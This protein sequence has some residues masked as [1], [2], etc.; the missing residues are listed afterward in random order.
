MKLKPLLASLYEPFGNEWVKQ[1]GIIFDQARKH[2]LTLAGSIA[3]AVGRKKA[4]RP[5]GDIDFVC[6]DIT[7]ARAF[8]HGL[9]D[10]LL[11]RSVYWK[12]QTNSKTS[13]CPRGCTAHVRFTAPFWLPVCVMV[14]PEVHAWLI[15]GGY[16]IQQFNDVVAA[17]KELD[18]RDGKGRVD[19]IVQEQDSESPGPLGFHPAQLEEDAGLIA[20]F[21]QG[22]KPAH[23]EGNA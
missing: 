1:N 12:V 13:F 11:T 10:F 23:Y 19:D 21:V 3:I 18:S 15:E 6:V 20:E 9:E 14:I 2:S 16:S 8:V 17:A 4:I 5:P 7:Q 22:R